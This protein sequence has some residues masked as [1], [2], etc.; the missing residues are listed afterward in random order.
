M[1]YRLVWLVF[2]VPLRLYFR[3][4]FIGRENVPEGAHILSGNHASYLDP[5][6]LALSGYRPV[7]YMAKSE[8]FEHSAWFTWLLRQVRAFP[9]RRGTPDRQAIATASALLEAGRRVGIFPEGTRADVDVAD[10]GFGAAFG[11]AA[12]VALRSDVPIVPVGIAGT[13]KAMPRGSIWIRPARVRIVFGDPLTPQD[14]GD[15]SR[16]ERVDALTAM[17]MERIADAVR[18][19]GGEES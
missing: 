4:T 1:F 10:G 6:L 18:A 15:G 12:L 17:L 19:A 3:L 13:D 2:Y 8:L 7:H 14:A 9:I 16:R 11:G 5:A